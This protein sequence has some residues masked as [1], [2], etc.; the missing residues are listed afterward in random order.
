[1][2]ALPGLTIMAAVLALNLLS[3]A[4]ND[5]LNPKLRRRTAAAPAAPLPTP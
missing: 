1:M 3:D 4:V 2:T 5:A